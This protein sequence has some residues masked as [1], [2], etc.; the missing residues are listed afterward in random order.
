MN[1]GLATQ[2]QFEQF[3]ASLK[4]LDSLYLDNNQLKDVS[5]LSNLNLTN[6]KFLSLKDNPIPKEQI[7]NLQIALPNCKI[8]F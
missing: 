1:L 3:K 2:A 7:D 4:N 5:S 8:N 6:L